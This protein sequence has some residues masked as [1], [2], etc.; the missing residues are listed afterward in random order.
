MV[1][2]SPMRHQ[3]HLRELN[4]K[5][6]RWEFSTRVE[7]AGGTLMENSLQNLLLCFLGF[8]PAG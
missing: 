2:K 6:Q 5:N 3:A 1:Q 8:F 7:A 4:A